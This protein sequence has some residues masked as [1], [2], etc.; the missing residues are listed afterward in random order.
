MSDEI[1]RSIMRASRA[2]SRRELIQSKRTRHTDMLPEINQEE[3]HSK[4]M[5]LQV[6]DHLREENEQLHQELAML[7]AQVEA[8]QSSMNLLEREIEALRHEEPLHVEQELTT[9][10]A[11]LEAYQNGTHRLENEIAV[12]QHVHRQEI[13]Q[14]Q[15]QI[16]VMLDE[17]EH[18]QKINQ[19]WEQR[20]QELYRDFHDAVEE[21]ASKMVK[22][23]A[24]TLVL[25]PEQ[26]PALLSDVVQALEGQLRQSEDQRTAELLE[27]MRQA[28]YKAELLEQE[29]AREQVAL[30]TERENLRQR[31]VTISEQAQQR[32]QLERTRLQGRWTA[33]LTAASLILLS[34]MVALELIFHSL[35]VPL[36]IA[37]F[38]PLG[39]CFAVSYVF[40]HLHT[41]GRIH[42]HLRSH[43]QKS[44]KKAT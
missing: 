41:S 29:V 24:H 3:T 4:L 5:R 19:Q 26:T 13:E 10:Q 44:P 14:Y 22:E 30:A 8:Y 25:A 37:I 11:Q 1:G 43:P 36:Y 28:L 20:Y 32:Y 16:R 35:N 7:Q 12:V 15:Q 38:V 42:V 34:L 31:E 18:M 40:A 17:Q 39:I 9:L 21:E 2:A 6:V 23:A 33:G 27:V